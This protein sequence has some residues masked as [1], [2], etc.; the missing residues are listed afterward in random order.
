[1]QFVCRVPVR[2]T[3]NTVSSPVFPIEIYNSL[4]DN[5]VASVDMHI[6]EVC[7]V[8]FPGHIIV[9][10]RDVSLCFPLFKVKSLSS[11]KHLKRHT[12]EAV[13]TNRKGLLVGNTH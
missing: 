5:E 10:G 9:R 3:K 13:K 11:M 6:T 4:L 12:K 1:M 7:S 2:H 8:N